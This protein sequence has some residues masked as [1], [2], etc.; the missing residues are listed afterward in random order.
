MEIIR[1]GNTNCYAIRPDST[2][3][4]VLIDAGTSDDTGFVKNLES[5]GIFQD[6][7]MIILTHGHYDHVGHAAEIGS[8]LGIPVAIHKADAEKVMTGSMDFPPAEGPLGK[9][10]R[11]STL[12]GSERARYPPLTPDIIIEDEGPLDGFPEM[13]VI[14]LPGHTA[15]S[16]GIMFDGDLFAGDLVMNM[17]TPSRSM[18]AEDFGE[19]DRSIRKVQ[20]M[21]IGTVYPGHGRPFSGDRLRRL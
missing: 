2:G 6:I 1:S 3:D 10:I 5:K 7:R 18:F 4:V 9:A 17:P 8:R 15:G 21:G 16:I 12:R 14:H 20:G 19:L 11:R 13:V